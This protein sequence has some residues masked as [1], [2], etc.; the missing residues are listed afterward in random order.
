MMA[1]F[2]ALGAAFG[3]AE[4]GTPG[5]VFGAVIGAGIGF[6]A[7]RDDRG[8]SSPHDT[9]EDRVLALFEERR[10]LQEQADVARALDRLEDPGASPSKREAYRRAVRQLYFG[11]GDLETRRRLIAVERRLDAEVGGGMGLFTEL[12]ASTGTREYM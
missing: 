9:R 12:E 10:K 7:T 3:F 6:G 4:Y 2:G 8:R 1:L 5:A 11:I